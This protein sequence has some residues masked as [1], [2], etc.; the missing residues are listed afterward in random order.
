LDITDSQ[1]IDAAVRQ[2]QNEVGYLSLLVNNAAISNAGPPGRTMEEIFETQR[3]SIA[4]IKEMK[5]V[6]ETNVFGTLALF[7]PCNF[8]PINLTYRQVT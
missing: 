5:T 2:I 8:F 7:L 6:W 3:A 4:P 1:S